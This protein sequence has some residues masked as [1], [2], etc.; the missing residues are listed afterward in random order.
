MLQKD[1]NLFLLL[2]T[3]VVVTSMTITMVFLNIL[4]FFFYTLIIKDIFPY[5]VL[6]LPMVP[7]FYFYSWSRYVINLIINNHTKNNSLYLNN[8]VSLYLFL[9][10]IIIAF[11]LY[12]SSLERWIFWISETNPAF[13]KITISLTFTT[14]IIFEILHRKKFLGAQNSN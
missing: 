11:F 1:H 10:N 14:L 12:F 4:T 5:I 13:I 9:I 7:V 3:I 2:F 8:I 6:L